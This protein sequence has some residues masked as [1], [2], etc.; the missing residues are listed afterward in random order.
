MQALR[1]AARAT[2]IRYFDLEGYILPRWTELIGTLAAGSR[3]P[4]QP[5]TPGLATAQGLR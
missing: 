3:P 4:E 1:D 2:A 5:A